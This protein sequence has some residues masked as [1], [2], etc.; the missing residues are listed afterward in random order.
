MFRCVA[1]MIILLTA[2]F[3]GCTDSTPNRTIVTFQ[4]DTDGDDFW[5]YLYTVPRTKMNN[6]T[7]SSE[8]GDDTVSS[9]FSHQKSLSLDDMDKDELGYA[10]FSFRADFFNLQLE[11]EIVYVTDPSSGSGRNANADASTRNG[12]TLAGDYYVFDDL[13][14][15]AEYSYVDAEFTEGVNDGK[16]VAWVANH[17]GR[18]ALDYSLTEILGLYT[19][20]VYT[21]DKYRD[22]DNSNSLDKL[23]AYWLVNLAVNYNYDDL[24]LSFRT[25]NLFNEKYASYVFDSDWYSGNE[26][27]YYLNATYDF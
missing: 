19:D 23:D 22:G 27:A 16:D 6:F 24:T 4:I 3:A 25:E 15:S 18:V 7:I 8:L 2:S 17:T 21:G 20:A 13:L 9:V 5:I 12:A 10:T 14:L 1:F 11:D 26:R